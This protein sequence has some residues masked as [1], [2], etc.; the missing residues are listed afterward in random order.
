MKARQ[1]IW[2]SLVLFASIQTPVSGQSLPELPHTCSIITKLPDLQN[3]TIKTVGPVNRDYKD[4][5][6]AIDAAQGKACSF[7]MRV[8][9][10][11]EALDCPRKV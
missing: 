7:W 10:L 4:L 6:Q 8:L 9:H 2:F 5:Q 11:W 1:F 3:F